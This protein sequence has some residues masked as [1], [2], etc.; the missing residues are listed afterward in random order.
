MLIAASEVEVLDP[1][2]SPSNASSAFS[3]LLT[4]ES[5][6]PKVW[7][8]AFT[9]ESKSWN[10]PLCVP[11][12]DEGT[13]VPVAEGNEVAVDVLEAVIPEKRPARPGKSVFFAV[14]TAVVVPETGWV[15]VKYS[16]PVIKVFDVGVGIIT[17]V[18]SV[19]PV[20]V[21]RFPVLVVMSVPLNAA[22]ISPIAL[23]EDVVNRRGA[24]AESCKPANI[25]AKN[26]NFAILSW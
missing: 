15:G 5:D 3:T 25:N 11:L 6:N 7:A 18:R 17:L 2:T 23:S 10:I 26:C 22:K 4:T 16:S 24:D 13:D 1:D 21:S 19:I 20:G 9:T 14:E 8:K 12:L